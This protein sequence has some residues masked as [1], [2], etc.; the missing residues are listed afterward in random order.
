[1]ALLREEIEQIAQSVADRV[2][3]RSGLV[4]SCEN[5]E[6]AFLQGIE[7][8]IPH[9][10]PDIRSDF[11][12]KLNAMA[13]QCGFERDANGNW[14]Q[15]P[16]QEAVLQKIGPFTIIKEHDD[17]DLTIDSKNLGLAVV[18][19]D[20]EVFTKPTMPIAVH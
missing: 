2:V 5:I 1:M 7:R 15:F 17:G 11:N 12:K 13:K 10:S 9:F 18:T 6:P 3:V 14:E 16:K 8:D 19:T 20:G 4:C